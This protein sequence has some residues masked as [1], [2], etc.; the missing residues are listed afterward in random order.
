[1]TI[2][3][4]E[5]TEIK[6]TVKKFLI[7]LIKDISLRDTYDGETTMAIWKK[8]PEINISRFRGLLDRNGREPGFISKI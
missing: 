4:L 3:F 1:M 8:I 6:S 7:W 5:F 2:A